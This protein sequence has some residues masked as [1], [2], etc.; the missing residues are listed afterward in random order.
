MTTEPLT[1]RRIETL[2]WVALFIALTTGIGFESDWGRRWI[3]PLEQTDPRPA[4]FTKPSLTEPFSLPVAD[5]FMEIALRP[6]FVVT[7]RPSPTATVEAQKPRMKKDQFTLTGTTLVPEGKFAHLIEKSGNKS[8]VVLEGKEINGILLKEVRADRVVLVQHD[9]TEVVMLF[10]WKA[11]LKPTPPVPSPATPQA[12][13]TTPPTGTPDQ[14]T[15][16]TGRTASLP[17]PVSA[18]PTR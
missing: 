3:L 10:A 1:P 2:I 4:S 14:P 7:R 8:H 9:E 6:I 13:T 12:G 18:P 16:R 15:S 5:T 17:I 11:P